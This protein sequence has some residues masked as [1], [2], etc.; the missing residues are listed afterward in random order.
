MF[1]RIPMFKVVRVLTL[2]LSIGLVLVTTPSAL[3]QSTGSA[4]LRGTL[5]D[6]QGALI[7]GATVTLI[8]EATKDERKVK[9]NDSGL[10][11]FS[12]LNPGVYTV[13]VESSGFKTAER[14]THLTV[15]PGDTRGL[16]ILMEVGAPTD[17]VTV[18][19]CS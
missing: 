11:V 18:T 4:T 5:K 12:A 7:G 16:E 6:P 9:T 3:A 19:A 13:K 8:N 2:L 1:W 15:S 17:T 14:K 10:F